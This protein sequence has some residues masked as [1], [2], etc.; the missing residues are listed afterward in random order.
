M[1]NTYTTSW[2][3]VSNGDSTTHNP[4]SLVSTNRPIEVLSAQIQWEG[5]Q[6]SSTSCNTDYSYNTNSASATASTDTAGNTN[7]GSAT[8]TQTSDS[9]TDSNTAQDS[10]S[11]SSVATFPD[12]PSGSTFEE[13]KLTVTIDA[14]VANTDV[15][16]TYADINGN[17]QSTTV[18]AGNYSTVYV[19][20][21]TTDYTGENRSLSIED[22]PDYV[23]GTIDAKTTWSSIES[24]TVT[25]TAPSEPSGYNFEYVRVKKYENGNVVSNTKY[26]STVYRDN[27]EWEKTSSDPDTTV[28][29]TSVIV[30]VS[31]PPIRIIHGN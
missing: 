8:A 1:A 18:S 9:F 17:I 22:H 28:K 24:D 7:S 23:D 10:D 4:G 29:I 5:E 27:G 26:N 31:P 30:V 25:I 3:S 16:V 12:V 2:F 19:S 13:V 14:T 21:T 15:N 20:N 11:I 6:T